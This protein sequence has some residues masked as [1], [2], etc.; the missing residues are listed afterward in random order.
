MRPE[1]RIQDH[2]AFLYGREGAEQVW[3]RLQKR[4]S[5]FRERNSGLEASETVPAERLTE[6]D[7][8][9][10]TY[11]DQ[12]SESGK[13]PLQTLAELLEQY[14]AGIVTGAHLLPFFPYSSDDG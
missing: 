10:I 1:T 9:L 5:S 7:V 2:L 4:L 6:R 8:F 3:P 12:V 13:P 14:V 11:G